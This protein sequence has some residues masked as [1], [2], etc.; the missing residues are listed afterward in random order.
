MMEKMNIKL[1]YQY[2]KSCI[3]IVNNGHKLQGIA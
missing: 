2:D 3:K 1:E